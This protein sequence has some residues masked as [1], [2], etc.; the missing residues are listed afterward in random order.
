VPE[1]KVEE[2]FKISGVP[3]FTFVEP[4]EYSK[5]LVSLRTPGRGLVVEGPSGIGKTSAVETALRKLDVRDATKLSARKPADVELIEQLPTM[6]SIGVVIVDDFH[7]LNDAVKQKLAD[8]M[9][10]LAD[11]ERHDAKLVIVGINRAGER[12]LSFAADLANRID[13]IA[14][15]NNPE[16]KV[17]E[18]L[19]KGEAA[20]NITFNVTDE[21]VAAAEGSFYIAQLLAHEVCVRADVLEKQSPAR[22]IELSFEAVRAS[23]WDRL[24]MVFKE[25]CRRFCQG[26]KMKPAGRAPYLHIL[27]ALAEGSQWSLSFR[28][29]RPFGSL[30]GSVGQVVEKGFLETLISGDD[31]IRSMLHYDPG[32]QIL[33]IEDPQVAFFIKHIPW[34]H[35]AREIGFIGVTFEKRYD[36]ALSFAGTDRPVAEALFNAL[37]EEQL[38]VFYDR[39]EQHRI[40][41]ENVEEYLRPIYQSEADF[42]L[43]LLGLDYPKRIWT[44]FESDAFKERFVDGSVIP[45]WFS[46]APTGIFDETR[47]VGGLE[48][49]PAGNLDEQV[50]NITATL[51]RKLQERRAEEATAEAP[52][53]GD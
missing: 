9:K 6:G 4:V 14:F 30:R 12:L 10:T 5:L 24:A 37:S 26:T 22:R 11:E 35:F 3:S 40:L 48:F 13:V 17:R 2:V 36:F 15:E 46:T 34:A 38:S 33:T 20:L 49:D 7:R 1:P 47:R 45:I 44:K 29:L 39:N 21:I 25:P 27:H 52:S 18:V 53:D 43:C 51:V 31:K 32:A 16:H 42:V 23:V 28:D 50:S 8:F 19:R 41:A